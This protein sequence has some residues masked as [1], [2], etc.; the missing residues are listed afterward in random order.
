MTTDPTTFNS[1]QLAGWIG[2]L[3]FLAGGLNQLLRLT[4]RF[5]EQPPPA[6][7][8]ATKEELGLLRQELGRL[9]AEVRDDR[10]RI[11]AA[12]EERARKLHERIDPI[13]NEMPGKIIELLRNTGALL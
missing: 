12:G 10:D 6:Q 1:L 2:S 5:K 7:T 9:R 13:I 3:F 8:Y 4:D 11:L